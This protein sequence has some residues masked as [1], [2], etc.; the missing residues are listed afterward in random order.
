MSLDTL[1][2]GAG[3]AGLRC[4]AGLREA[5]RRVLVLDRARA[6]GGRCA[7]RRFDGQ[8]VDFGPQF[9]QGQ[10]PAFL[11]AL[12]QVGTPL[13][14][15][16]LRVEG[17]GVPCQPRPP[18]GAGFRVVLPEGLRAFPARLALGL[19]IRLET[20]VTGLRVVDGGFEVST[21]D[22]SRLR[23][24]DLVLALALEQGRRLLRGLPETREAE[25]LRALLELFASAPCLALVAGYAPGHPDPGWDLLYP[26]A[27]EVLQLLAHDS[28]KRPDPRASVFVAQARPRWSRLHMGL[29]PEAWSALLL[30]EVVRIL[31]PWAG[32]PLWTF[33][34]RWEFARVDGGGELARPP[35]IVFGEGQA[36]GL[37][38][39]VFAPGGGVQAAWLSGGRLAERMIGKERE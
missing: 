11:E 6:V 2:V 3:V 19:D 23:C 9:L 27:S 1:V 29:D 5:G 32:S 4:A 22:G 7:T 8:P 39:D 28:T 10:W 34:H 13:V 14:P 30:E 18:E 17:K 20:E 33:T 24:R 15:W 37:A 38:G 31:G 35:R 16:P 26:E 25:G 12:R 36:L 21:A